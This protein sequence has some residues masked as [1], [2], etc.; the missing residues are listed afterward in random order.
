MNHAMNKMPKVMLAAILIF[1]G[2]ASLSAQYVRERVN[3]YFTTE[4]MPDLRKFLPA[5]PDSI[6]NKFTYDVSQYMWGKEMRK[7]REEFVRLTT[8]AVAEPARRSARSARRAARQQAR[9]Y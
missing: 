9:A 5:P 6:I 4:E 8:P 2:S 1:C 7:A 3:A